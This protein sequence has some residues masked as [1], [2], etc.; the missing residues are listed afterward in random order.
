MTSKEYARQALRGALTVRRAAGIDKDMPLCVF[1][2]AEKL[3]NKVTF[4][5]GN[6]FGGMYDRSS[7]RILVPSQRNPGYQTFTAAHELGH[8]HF[9]H[10]SRIDADKDM[11]CLNHNSLEERLANI[12]AG[13]LLMTPWAVERVFSRRGWDPAT[14]SPLEM[15]LCAAQLGVGYGSLLQHLC[16]S[17][18]MISPERLRR[19]FKSSPKSLRQCL[20]SEG[21]N[22]NGQGDLWNAA[23]ENTPNRPFP[24]TEH[25][26]V[27]DARWEEITIDLRVG[28]AAI[29]PASVEIEGKAINHWGPHPRGEL[30]LGATPGL[31][32]ATAPDGNWAVFLRVCR[33]EYAGHSRYRHLEDPDDNANI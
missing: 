8:W 13:Y 3:G 31:A 10:G 28:D 12:F 27:A 22:A 16:W 4:C 1:D 7:G 11:G 15:S 26:V 17:L 6:S 18:Q 25:L 5:P 30:V 33:R 9:R 32:R 29:L 20:L 23:L 2:V 24:T 14:C 21:W 19:L